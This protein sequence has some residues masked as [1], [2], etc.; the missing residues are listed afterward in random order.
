MTDS[1]KTQKITMGIISDTHG[2]LSPRIHDIFRGVDG[3]V[4]AGDIGDAAILDELGMLAPVVAVRGNMD[5]GD[6]SSRLPPVEIL[7]Q[8]RIRIGVV[9]DPQQWPEDLPSNE[10][11]VIICGHTHRALIAEKNGVLFVNPGSAGEPRGGR[12]A[13]VALLRIEGL[14]VNADIVQLE[15]GSG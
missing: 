4:H 13:T 12:P 6:W 3:I 14:T 11:R 10:C 2:R 1:A 5:W 8:G 15:S 7:F 9:H